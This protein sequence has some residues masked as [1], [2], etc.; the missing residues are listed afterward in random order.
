METQAGELMKEEVLA[1]VFLECP[2]LIRDAMSGSVTEYYDSSGGAGTERSIGGLAGGLFG[3]LATGSAQKSSLGA[4][5]AYYVAVGPTKLAFFSIKVGWVRRS[6]NTLLAEYRRS[7]LKGLEIKNGYMSRATFLF[8]D[9]TSLIL[10]CA[11]LMRS[12][13]MKLE[14]VLNAG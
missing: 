4:G 2:Q 6:I 8:A 10:M 5:G 9:D 1:A 3:R 14:Q 12:R 13:L 11:R 7:D